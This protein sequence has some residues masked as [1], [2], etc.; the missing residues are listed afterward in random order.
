MF[1]IYNVMYAIYIYVCYIY[2]YI[3]I[4]YMYIK[5]MHF[6]ILFSKAGTYF[7]TLLV[8]W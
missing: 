7:L 4:T 3:Y 5:Q 2:I 8:V 1:Y 6:I